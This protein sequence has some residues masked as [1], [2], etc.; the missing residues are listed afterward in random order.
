MSNVMIEIS[1]ICRWIG[2]IISCYDKFIGCELCIFSF[3]IEWIFYFFDRDNF[4]VSYNLIIKFFYFIFK[5]VND[6]MRFISSREYMFMIFFFKCD[7]VVLKEVNNIMVIKL[8][9]D[10]I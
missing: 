2:F 7:V 4:C 9:E 1:R 6:S 5:G 10:V 3:D 8:W